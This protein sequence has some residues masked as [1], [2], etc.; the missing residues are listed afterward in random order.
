MELTDDYTRAK[1][2]IKAKVTRAV[3]GFGFLD[4]DAPATTLWKV[5]NGEWMYY[6]DQS[7]TLDTPFGPV[8]EQKGNG[9]PPP[10]KLP[11]LSSFQNL[12]KL[13]R[14]AVELAPDGPAQTVTVSNDLPG[15]VDLELQSGKI[16]G[17]SAQLEKKH[18][19]AG[20]KT[21]IRFRST[22]AEKG[23]GVVHVVVAPFGTQLDI[24]VKVN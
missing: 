12:V 8:K 11:D 18:L 7:A 20:E 19:E 17:L 5:E 15:G 9:P 13:D 23:A 4:F 2:T 6:I 1:V 10:R 3:P 16:A 22:G 24:T 14:T 21:V